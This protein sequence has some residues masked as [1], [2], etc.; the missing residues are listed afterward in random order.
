MAQTTSS[1]TFCP[2]ILTLLETFYALGDES[3]PEEAVLIEPG[4]M[5][6]PYRSLLVHQRDMTSTLTNYYR[7]TIK[8]R[9]LDRVFTP[10]KLSRHVVLECAGTDRPVEYGASRIS[11]DLL[12]QPARR[13]ILEGRVP[14]GGILHD[15]GV[16]YGNCPRAYFS[17]RSNGLIGRVFGLEEPRWLFG[18]C[19]C[20][21]DRL[22]RTIAEVVEIL[23][24]EEQP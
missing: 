9:V 11:L 7:D 13:K 10:G 19:N 14:L 6:E 17:V 4:Q 21:S 20:L 2:K 23:P 12:D 15:F 24:P 18:R 8:L 16:R 3:P 1:T 5:P 22:G